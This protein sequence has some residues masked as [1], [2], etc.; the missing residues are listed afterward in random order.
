M[1]VEIFILSGARAGEQIILDAT[2]FRVGGEPN[3]EVVF[4][5]RQDLPAKGRSAAF[6]L[7]DDGWYVSRTGIGELLVNQEV[8]TGR[9][10]IR[11]GDVLRM[12]NEGPDLVFSLVSHATAVAA[13]PGRTPDMQSASRTSPPAV[14]QSESPVSTAPLSAKTPVSATDAQASVQKADEPSSPATRTLRPIAWASLIGGGLAIIVLVVCLVSYF[15][16]PSTGSPA[17]AADEE[18]TKTGADDT[19]LRNERNIKLI[20]EAREKRRKSQEEKKA[21]LEKEHLQREQ[22]AIK[23]REPPKNQP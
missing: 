22:E 2:E 4:D 13:V 14:V 12:S 20:K 5:P 8:V 18:L 3:C 19:P 9:A 11:S 21:Q 17:P 23:K 1:S 6:R 16:P 7:M 10:R 15:M